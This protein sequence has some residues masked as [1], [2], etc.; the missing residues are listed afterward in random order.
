MSKSFFFLV[1]L[2]FIQCVFGQTSLDW[3][4]FADINF[5]PAYNEIHEVYF[6]KPTFG[7]EIKKHQGETISIT[8]Y[9]LDIAGDGG[10]LLVSQ[11]PMASC[12]FCGASGPESV[13]E[14]NFKS[15]PPFKTDQVV[16]ITGVLELNKYDVDHF[17][18]ILNKA[19]GQLTEQ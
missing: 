3:E 5:E 4:D 14:I 18:Y 11:N 16:T 19:E 2:F 13:I 15:V 7:N 17:N 9:F 1:N 10:V 6:L 8:G 12:F